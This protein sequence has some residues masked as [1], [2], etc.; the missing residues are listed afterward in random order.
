MYDEIMNRPM[1]QTPQ[2]RQGAGIMAGVAPVRG[3]AD[4]DFG[5]R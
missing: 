2:Q 1:F 4:G 3:Y 5:F